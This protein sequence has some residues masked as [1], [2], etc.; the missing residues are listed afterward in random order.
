MVGP[1]NNRW[2]LA[3]LRRQPRISVAS[4]VCKRWRAAAL[5]TITRLVPLMVTPAL[6]FLASPNLVTCLALLQPPHLSTLKELALPLPAQVRALTLHRPPHNCGHFASSRHLSALTSLTEYNEG[7]LSTCFCLIDLIRRNAASLATL[8]LRR[9][10]Q[11]TAS[12]YSAVASL[13]LASLTSLTLDNP[14]PAVCT[15]IHRLSSQLVEL[16]LAAQ[17]TLLATSCA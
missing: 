3:R 16:R 17:D 7:E 5:S 1:R 14:T 8:A 13:A 9:S 6:R 4:L 11:G 10:F 2:M 12:A 15:F